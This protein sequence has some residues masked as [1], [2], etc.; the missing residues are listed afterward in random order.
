MHDPA[1][2]PARRRLAIALIALVLIALFLVG[3]AM[4]VERRWSEMRRHADALEARIEAWDDARPALFG[5]AQPGRAWDG[6]ADAIAII[7]SHGKG[8]AD[9]IA[10]LWET[11][12]AAD[13]AARDAVVTSLAP[14][15]EAL[16]RGAHRA[17][18]SVPVEWSAGFSG[19]L[20]NPMSCRAL[21]DLAVMRA[22]QLLDGGEP[23]RAVEALL[24]AAQFGRDLAHAPVWITELIGIANV[25][26]AID[27][28][29]GRHRLLD[30]LPAPALQR[31]RSGLANL[32]EHFSRASRGALLEQDARVRDGTNP[33]VCAV[34]AETEG[35]T[36]S[37]LELIARLRLWRSKPMTC[38]YL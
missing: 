38:K 22:H 31:L 13:P 7:E 20:P 27:R 5:A 2:R 19:S 25:S 10:R 8:V 17:D 24:D 35:L 37:R 1:T 34:G 23:V 30:R 9:E 29:L 4:Q 28:Q 15:V 32:D 18:G 6:Y 3:F 33:L 16:A 21:A 11:G 12:G 26:V 36:V 14:A